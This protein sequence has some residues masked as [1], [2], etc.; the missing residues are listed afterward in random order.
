M[1]LNLLLFIL[2]IFLFIKKIKS[3]N[4][5]KGMIFMHNDDNKFLYEDDALFLY[6]MTQ[7]NLY[8]YNDA[9]VRVFNTLSDLSKKGYQKATDFI[10]NNY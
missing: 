9:R 3:E 8:T 2:F 5:L 4:L 1:K 7:Y 6:A 10:K